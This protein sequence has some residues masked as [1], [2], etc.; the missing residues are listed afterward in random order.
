MGASGK[1]N[2]NH[3]ALVAYKQLDSCTDAPVVS[4]AVSY[5]AD[6]P[7]PV[8]L[9]SEFS[10]SSDEVIS[11]VHEWSPEPGMWSLTRESFACFG[12][13]RGSSHSGLAPWLGKQ[14]KR[15]SGVSSLG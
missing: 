12:R 10:A 1:L 9:F 6:M 5:D 2:K 4:H 13:G 15:S 8:L 7:D 14:H 3:V 11:R